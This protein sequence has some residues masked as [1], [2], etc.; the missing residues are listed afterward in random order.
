M[1][2]WDLFIYALSLLFCFV[3]RD[4]ISPAVLKMEYGIATVK[5]QY[6]KKYKARQLLGSIN[7]K[8]HTHDS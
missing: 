6:D 2:V 3:C 5:D 8:S 7:E 1:F 4:Y